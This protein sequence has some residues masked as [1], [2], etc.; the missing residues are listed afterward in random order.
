MTTEFKKNQTSFQGRPSTQGNQISMRIKSNFV[1]DGKK[2][3]VDWF[4]L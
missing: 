2:T 3:Y 1:Q 4:K